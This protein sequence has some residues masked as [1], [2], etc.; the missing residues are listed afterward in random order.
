VD[1]LE[2]SGY[3]DDFRKAINRELGQMDLVEFTLSRLQPQALSGNLIP[4]CSTS[5][6]ISHMLKWP[7]L[8]RIV[9]RK[10]PLGRL[11][12]ND[13]DGCLLPSP[14]SVKGNCHSLR[15][16]FFSPGDIVLT[17]KHLLMLSEMT[18][19]VERASLTIEDKSIEALQ[20]CLRSW[21]STLIHLSLS[22]IDCNF[23]EA[24]SLAATCSSLRGLRSL[25]VFSAAIPPD[26]LVDFTQLGSLVYF[27][28]AE[29]LEA[30]VD[31]LRDKPSLPS[32]RDLLVIFREANMHWKER[33]TARRRFQTTAGF[34]IHDIGK[35][36]KIHIDYSLNQAP[37][38]PESN[39]EFICEAS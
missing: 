9:I 36:R 6:M 1:H 31:I 12:D 7:R 27:V 17:S 23:N 28:T 2:I 34:A 35:D 39:V 32:L 25:T 13:N 18:P 4:F 8:Q 5:Q 29:H 11:G 33:S 19:K 10:V 16:M 15:E 21:S 14:S 30:L 24:P 37:S 22:P 20:T 3:H 38:P 26:A